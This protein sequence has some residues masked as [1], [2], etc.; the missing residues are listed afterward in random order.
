MLVCIIEFGT[1]PGMAE[2]NKELV[3]NLLV[4]ARQHDGFISKETFVSRDN[5]DKVVTMSY[6][7]DAEALRLWMRHEEHL[8]TI[9]IGRNELFS[10]YSIQVGEIVTNKNWRKSGT[11]AGGIGKV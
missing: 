2:R 11:V 10:H 4:H 5:P 9:P 3:T 6:W 8:K 7:R 1:L